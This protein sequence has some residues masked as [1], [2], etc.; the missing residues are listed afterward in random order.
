MSEVTNGFSA[1]IERFEQK[2]G[3]L[4]LELELFGCELNTNAEKL[5]KLVSGVRVCNL[6]K[7]VFIETKHTLIFSFLTVLFYTSEV[8]C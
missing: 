3:L 1:R 7:E 2:M 8:R 5:R 6:L 4:Q